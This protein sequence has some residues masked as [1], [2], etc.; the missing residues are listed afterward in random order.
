MTE[1]ELEEAFD[2]ASVTAKVDLNNRCIEYEPSEEQL[3]QALD[4][5][6]YLRTEE[7]NVVVIVESFETPL[8][9]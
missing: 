2:D 4:N 1:E 3:N 5:A 8:E 6:V 7:E 9:E